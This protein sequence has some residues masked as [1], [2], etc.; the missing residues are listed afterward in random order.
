MAGRSDIK[1]SMALME[2]DLRAGKVHL[3]PMNYPHNQE[4]KDLMADTARKA[5]AKIQ[6]D[7][8]VQALVAKKTKDDADAAHQRA[9]NQNQIPTKPGQI[10]MHNK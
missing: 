4:I 3:E 2:A 6:G 1:D 8:E 5:W 9:S 10:I 7:P